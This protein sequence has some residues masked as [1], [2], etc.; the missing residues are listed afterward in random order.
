MYIYRNGPGDVAPRGVFGRAHARA[1][2]SSNL[3]SS[4]VHAVS[5]GPFSIS[6]LAVRGE[7]GCC[8][9]THGTG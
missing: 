3:N 7:I 1:R 6:L 2:T 4:F 9:L 5:S 8:I